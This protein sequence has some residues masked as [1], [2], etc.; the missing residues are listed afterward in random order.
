MYDP[1]PSGDDAEFEWLEIF[2]A[3][4]EP[5]D[6]VGW[7][8]SDNSASD[9]LPSLRLMPHGFAVIAASERIRDAYPASG[10]AMVALAD[11]RIGAGLANKGDHLLLRDSA[12]K[13]ADGV[14]WGDDETVLWP[15]VAII[16]SG[17]SIERSPVGRDTDAAADFV[18]NANPSPGRGIGE[19]A[20]AAA[21]VQRQAAGSSVVYPPPQ[22]AE[23]ASS[24]LARRS[25]VSIAASVVALAVGLSAGLY[26]RWR[27]RQWP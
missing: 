26:G 1:A 15:S 9:T 10:G 16:P 5:V 23:E 25:L 3:G 6:L 13:L 17:H 14:S 27:F 24:N 2:N 20:V 21:A 4:G 22:T 19:Q 18:D 8:L 7:T 12:G 11:G